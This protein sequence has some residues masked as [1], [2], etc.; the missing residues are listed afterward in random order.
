MDKHIPISK[1]KDNFADA[2][3]GVAYAGDRVYLQRRGKDVAVIVSLEEVGKLDEA[4][5]K[6]LLAMS[7]EALEEHNSGDEKA[8]PWEEVK[9]EV[10][11]RN[12][13]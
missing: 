3:N 2:L 10:V 9:A 13:R 11:S 7:E 12:R 5:D 6:L 1:F 4:E 8:I